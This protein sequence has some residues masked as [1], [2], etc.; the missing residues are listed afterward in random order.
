MQNI[1]TISAEAK[2]LAAVKHDSLLPVKR[3]ML[4]GPSW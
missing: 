1:E 2:C 4:I 3:A